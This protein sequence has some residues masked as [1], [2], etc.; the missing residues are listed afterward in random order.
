[1]NE[2]GRGLRATAGVAVAAI[3]FTT[4]CTTDAPETVRSM[5]KLTYP[6]TERGA[7]VDDYHGT[8]VAD[9]YRWLEDL[10]GE[11][12]R[13]WVEKQNQ[14]S[15]PFL[16]SLPAR[17][18]IEKRLTD[19]WNYERRG[20]PF[21]KGDRFF[22]LHNDGL[23]NQDVLMVADAV[24]GEPRVLID[25]NDW[26]SDGKSALAGLE[27]SHDGRLAA[28]ARSEGGTD[29]RDWRVKEVDTGRD[30]PD[31]IT[32]TKFTPLSWTLD[33]GGFYYSR[34]PVGPDG[35]GDGTKAVAVWFHR[36]G[37]A[38][39]DDRE[40]FAVPD[41]PL[42]NA[43]ARVTDDGHW[44]V[45]SIAEGSLENAVWLID[46]TKPGASARPL[47]DAWD[48]RYDFVHNSGELFYFR[49]TLSAP[50][51]RLVSVKADAAP[52][53][54][55]QQVIPETESV[56]ESVSP[57]GGHFVV[58]YVDRA[59]AR[60]EIWH[61]G[62]RK[63]GLIDLPSLGNAEGFPDGWEDDETFFSFETFTQPGTIYRV[64]IP[65]GERSEVYRP[66]LPA[67]LSPFEARQ[68]FF[69][70]KDGT[71]IPMFIVH[72]RDLELDGSH[73]TLLYGYGGFDVSLTPSFNV[74]RLVWLELG[75]VYAVANLRGGGEL[76]EQWHL[77][78]ARTHKQ[79][80]FDDFI[81]AAERLREWGYTSPE[82][83]VIEG[84]SN[85]GLLVGAV[86]TQRP[87][88]FG[89][90]LADV[91]V[92]DMLR[93]HLP[94]LNAR[95]W[96]DDYGVSENEE[97]F[98][99]QIAYSPLHNVEPG[100]CY[101]PTLVTTADHDDRVVPWHSYKFAAAL[102][103]AQSCDHP[104]ALAVETRVGHGAGTPT[105]QMIEKLADRYAFAAWALGVEQAP[106]AGTS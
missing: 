67:D 72:R 31:L 86:I 33:A 60:V 105:A 13:A 80:V 20:V 83:L 8:S 77:A 79:N 50:R 41:H 70:S 61:P 34:H 93:Y 58:K 19:L 97:D 2:H 51:G 52:P 4:S 89:A 92:L 16:D 29:W 38:Q 42:R 94:S 65:S 68:V 15:R 14:V 40:V 56:L 46:L 39:D 55:L 10:D 35:Q 12:V 11:A 98:R 18:A 88:L 73:P 17:P 78:G 9:P 30:L 76:G 104:I 43:Y 53:I 48:A 100:T 99:A 59:I 87:E 7:Q 5:P 57:V 69:P 49:T 91:G 64:A 45:I 84:A 54:E 26:S 71:Q 23:Q 44:L 27:V 75:G 106:I 81:A 36:L 24:A 6:T 66:E 37:T 63:I 25:P 82:K 47:F 102:Q 21:K 103:A 3:I 85:G 95:Q 32:F 74:G 22:W 1:M 62:G 90:A 101:P 28:Y 96:S